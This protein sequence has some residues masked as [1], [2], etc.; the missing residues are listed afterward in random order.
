M[1]VGEYDSSSRD[2]AHIVT[3]SALIYGPSSSELIAL[4][5]RLC[6]AHVLARRW[7]PARD[8]LSRALAISAER[9]GREHRDT[10]RIR[11]VLRS[12]E[13]YAG[14]PGD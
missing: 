4:L 14:P 10:E 1:K 7:Q 13:R 8:A 6:K 5:E 12:L 9:N 3:M 11:E 2:L